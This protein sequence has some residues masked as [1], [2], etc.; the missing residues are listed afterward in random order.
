MPTL[1]STLKAA[2]SNKN[3][4]KYTCLFT[5]SCDNT[6]HK[7]CPTKKAQRSSVQFILFAF[8]NY[9]TKLHVIIIHLAGSPGSYVAY[10]KD[11]LKKRSKKLECKLS[12][13]EQKY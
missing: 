1:L 12:M 13:A 4:E 10:L 6:T 3:V 7:D 2:V 9:S 11:C 5:E 8:I